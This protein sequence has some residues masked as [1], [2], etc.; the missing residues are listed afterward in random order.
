MDIWKI[1]N[2]VGSTIF[3]L[4]FKFICIYISVYSCRVIVS[5]NL[6]ICIALT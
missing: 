3:Y 4:V 1:D 6:V 2:G 5:I